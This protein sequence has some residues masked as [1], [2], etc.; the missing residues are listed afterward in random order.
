MHLASIWERAVVFITTG[1]SGVCEPIDCM[2]EPVACLSDSPEQL[3]SP[4]TTA[5]VEDS[6]GEQGQGVS[7]LQGRGRERNV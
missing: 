1:E 2:H 3:L 4:L 5:S 7:M 6:C